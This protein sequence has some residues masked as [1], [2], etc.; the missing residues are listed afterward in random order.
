[1][2]LVVIEN[3]SDWRRREWS[4]YYKDLYLTTNPANAGNVI[5][6]MW[7]Q[8]NNP[9]KDKIKDQ[10]LLVVEDFLKTKIIKIGELVK[11]IS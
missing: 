2:S 1:M 5:W 8:N 6:Q 7:N 11:I 10:D 3:R 4:Q 9:N